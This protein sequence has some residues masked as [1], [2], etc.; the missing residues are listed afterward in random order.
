M[1]DTTEQRLR[2]DRIRS[3]SEVG[4]STPLGTPTLRMQAGLRRS[5]ELGYLL[6]LQYQGLLTPGQWAYLLGLQ[7]KVSSEELDS[8]IQLF[9]KLTKSPRSAARAHQDLSKV[10]S[11]TPHLS[12]KSIRREQRRIGVGY[13]DKG[14]LR[15]PHQDHDA[16]PRYW[17]WED[18]AQILHLSDDWMISEQLLAVE[19][20]AK[21][22]TILP[23]L[24]TLQARNCGSGKWDSLKPPSS[25]VR[26]P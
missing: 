18:I 10:L 12:T 7:R 2:E 5:V 3:F 11:K 24:K 16:P 9:G 25:R 17:W 6:Y 19:D 8:S 1:S 4:R 22:G 15:L 20:L 26:S 14:T 21:G 13:R 23:A